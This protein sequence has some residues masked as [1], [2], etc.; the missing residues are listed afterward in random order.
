MDVALPSSS[1]YVSYN[2]TV[3]EGET[4]TVCVLRSSTTARLEVAVKGNTNPQN[5]PALGKYPFSPS[6]YFQ[7]LLPTYYIGGVDYSPAQISLVFERS[8]QNQTKCGEFSI[9]QDGLDEVQETFILSV[10]QDNGRMIPGSITVNIDAC[11]QG[12]KY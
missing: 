6:S 3:P 1:S 5:F 7:V 2:I 10:A 8:S 9:I 12:G 11:K 4:L